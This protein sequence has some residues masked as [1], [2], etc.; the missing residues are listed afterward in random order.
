MANEFEECQCSVS[1]YA[2]RCGRYIWRDGTAPGACRSQALLSYSGQV[3]ISRRSN[4]A[5]IADVPYLGFSKSLE[6]L[7][8]LGQI[9]PTNLKTKKNIR[10]VE[11]Q[12]IVLDKRVEGLT[13]R[14]YQV[15]AMH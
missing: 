4:V 12:I 8:L 1:Q 13:S 15:N 6:G 10:D 9:Y 11:E 5:I 3:E 14:L 7:M 2:Q